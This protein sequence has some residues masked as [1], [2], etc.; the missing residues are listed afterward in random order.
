MPVLLSFSTLLTSE[1]HVRRAPFMRRADL[2]ALRTPLWALRV[3]LGFSTGRSA[4]CG[5]NSFAA[6][7]RFLFSEILVSSSSRCRTSA[8]I[9]DSSSRMSPTVRR[10]LS[11]RTGFFLGDLLVLMGSHYEHSYDFLQGE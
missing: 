6:S 7:N 2:G 1:A 3:G 11:A 4:A 9:A 5:R 10:A 8:A